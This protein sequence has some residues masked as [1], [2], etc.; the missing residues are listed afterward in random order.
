MIQGTGLTTSSRFVWKLM[1]ES[2]IKPCTVN[3][4]HKPITQ[5]EYS[6]RA[7]LS[8]LNNDGSILY[9]D[10]NYIQIINKNWVYLASVFDVKTRK[11]IAYNIDK[12]MTD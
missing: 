6:Q 9:T 1:H 10:I 12:Y 3:R 7:N 5:T 4:Y 8:Q 2:G 11:V